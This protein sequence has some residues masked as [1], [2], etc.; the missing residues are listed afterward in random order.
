MIFLP[1]NVLSH[2][3]NSPRIFLFARN[4]YRFLVEKTMWTNTLA[5]DSGICSSSIQPFQGCGSTRCVRSEGDALGWNIYPLRGWFEPI[6]GNC[7]ANHGR[8]LFYVSIPVIEAGVAYLRSGHPPHRGG[9]GF[10]TAIRTME[11][12]RTRGTSAWPSAGDF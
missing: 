3:F 10:S 5:S 12:I 1:H 8:W 4:G 7:P 2:T 9:S 11:E 6:V